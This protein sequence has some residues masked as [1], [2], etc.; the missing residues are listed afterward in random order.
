MRRAVLELDLSA[1]Q[2]NARELARYAGRETELMAI[3]KAN[4]YGHGAVVVS[5]ALR[6]A[7]VDSF[8]VATAAE[9]LELR[10]AV[11]RAAICVLGPVPS[12]ELDALL[13]AGVDLTVTSPEVAGLY[14]EAFARRVSTTRFHLKI[15]T[16]MARFGVA[17]GRAIG[18]AR[19][20]LDLPG[21]R[22]AS[23][24]THLADAEDPVLTELQI[25]RLEEVRSNLARID[26][27]CV[28]LRRSVVNSAGLALGYGRGHEL[29]RPGVALYGLDPTQ[30]RR[31]RDLGLALS[32]VLSLKS[33]VAAIREFPAGVPLGYGGR[34]RTQ[35]DQTRV[36]VVP[37]GYGDG[38]PSWPVGRGR[39]LVGGRRCEVLGSVMMD[40]ILVDVSCFGHS[41]V[42]VGAEVVVFGRQGSSE[43]RL[44]EIAAQ[45]GQLVYEVPCRLG[46]RLERRIRTATEGLDDQ[47]L[48]AA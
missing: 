14:A 19:R 46:G 31:F 41:G 21:A 9:A 26:A 24:S 15:D 3:V 4:A 48:N 44:E 28:G 37:V 42:G 13:D 20:L 33:R 1:L 11:S 29:A 45:V 2:A 38:L 10:A 17:P 47:A 35:R 22:L 5:E 30:G 6:S 7:G 27:R 39:V 40:N 12:A 23:I 25:A 8:G 16:G 43:I 36:A 32:P 34:A 18:V